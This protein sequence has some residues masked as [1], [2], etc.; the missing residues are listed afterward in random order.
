MACINKQ[1]DNVKP[2]TIGTTFTERAIPAPIL[3]SQV[4][5]SLETTV[6][7]DLKL[8]RVYPS[9]ISPLGLRLLRLFH[10]YKLKPLVLSHSLHFR[11]NAVHKLPPSCPRPGPWCLRRHQRCLLCW[12]N[13][14]CLSRHCHLHIWWR[15][16]YR[17]ILSQRSC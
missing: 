4:W 10:R 8:Q 11:Q 15:K 2:D 9:S 14:R 5:N 17:W 7:S 13:S 3:H 12:R 6:F 1:V 16:I